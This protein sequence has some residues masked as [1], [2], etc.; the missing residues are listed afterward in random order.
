MKTSPALHLAAFSWNPAISLPEATALALLFV[1]GALWLAW[2]VGAG[3]RAAIRFPLLTL[4][5]A[6]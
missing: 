3:T 6:G 2:R 1:A 5:G 4:R